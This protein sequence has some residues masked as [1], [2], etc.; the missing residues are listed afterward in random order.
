MLRDGQNLNRKVNKTA[1]AIFLSLLPI[2]IISVGIPVVNALILNVLIGR[3]LGESALA[4]QGYVN[5]VILLEMSMLIFG[6]GAQILCGQMMGR[7]DKEGVRGSFSVA[8]IATI[9]S[10]AILCGCMLFAPYEIAGILGA[11][12]DAIDITA[13][14]LKGLSFGVIPMLLF[15]TLLSFIVLECNAKLSM[16]AIFFNLTT[17]IL[18]TFLNLIVFKKGLFGVGIANSLSYIGALFLCVPHFLKK[19]GL[20]SFSFKNIRSGMLRTIILLGAPTSIMVAFDIF[21]NTWLNNIVTAYYGISGMAAFSLALNVTGNVGTVIQQSHQCAASIISSVLYGE[22]DVESLREL[23]KTT[24]SVI[25]PISFII[26]VMFCIFPAPISKLFGATVGTVPL[27]VHFF[28][29]YGNWILLDVLFSPSMAIYQSTGRSNVAFMIHTVTDF[30]FPMLL[31][32]F[33]TLTGKGNLVDIVS[34]S[35]T[36]FGIVMIVTYYL[37]KKRALPK[38]IFELTYIPS[39]FSVPAKDRFSDTIQTIEDAVNVSQKAIDFCI[40][41]NI[42]EGMSYYTGLCIEEVAVNTIESNPEIKKSDK[43]IKVIIIY[44]NHDISMIIRDN[45][46]Q[47]DPTEVLKK[48]DNSRDVAKSLGLRLVT[49]AA[50]EVNYSS[51]LNLNVLFISGMGKTSSKDT[52]L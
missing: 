37:I 41:K 34:I 52:F 20:F 24:M 17:S 1:K 4:A 7:G 23:P 29:L 36:V 15:Q 6:V 25:A 12:S 39:T 5:P 11:G 46:P 9:I 42:S 26:A 43:E 44:E 47:M 10:G 49:K 8:V 38:S 3:F 48:Y 50:K 21:R 51:A 2:Q 45:Y 16:T 30:V 22:R 27:Y 40:S 13:E 14:Y 18:F 19:D 28:R 33:I 32:G 31:L 35:Q